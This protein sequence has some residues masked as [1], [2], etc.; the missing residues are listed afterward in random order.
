MLDDAATNKSKV[1]EWTSNTEQNNALYVG[2]LVVLASTHTG[3]D[4]YEWQGMQDIIAISN[5]LGHPDIFIT[6][7]CNPNWP[8]TKNALL[9]DKSVDD[10][11][12][13]CDRVLHIKLKLL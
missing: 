10:R 1:S 8:E 7:N 2:R 12:E 13:L 3:I 5:S 11:P 6:M 9:L 4:R